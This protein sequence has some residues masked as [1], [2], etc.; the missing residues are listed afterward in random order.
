MPAWSLHEAQAL[1]K[2]WHASNLAFAPAAAPSLIWWLQAKR[3][4][5]RPAVN[6][7]EYEGMLDGEGHGD[8]AAAAGAGKD[9]DDFYQARPNS[10]RS[11]LLST[12]YERSS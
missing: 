1:R 8:A 6:D 9:D 4:R 12:E 11:E 2:D 7:F 3:A 5:T 10:S